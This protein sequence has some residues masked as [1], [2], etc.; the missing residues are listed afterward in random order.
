[1]KTRDKIEIDA[2]VERV[3]QVFTDIEHADKMLAA[4]ES[5]ELLGAPEFD[6]GFRWRE[7]RTMFG[8]QATE[9]MWVTICEPPRRY[10]VEAESHGARYLTSYRFEDLGDG[11][12]AVVQSFEGRGVTL[13][14][15][16]MT[17]VSLLFKRSTEKAFREDLEQM[18][19][20]CER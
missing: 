7:T 13:L 20:A 2:P 8:K 10:E 18:K 9:E 16:L 14:A 4:I 15:K 1:M 3:W 5:I 17:P 12:T 11:R 19:A 6:V